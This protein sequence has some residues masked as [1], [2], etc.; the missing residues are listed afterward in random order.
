[1]GSWP[2]V[3]AR[4]DYYKAMETRA[5]GARRNTTANV[6]GDYVEVSVKSVVGVNIG[7]LAW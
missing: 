6:D 7:G 1:M 3:D 5:A 2:M 4:N